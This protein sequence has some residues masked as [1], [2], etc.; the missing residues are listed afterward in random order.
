MYFL[1]I[2][3]VHSQNHYNFWNRIAVSHT[4]TENIKAEFEIQNRWQNDLYSNEK[5]WFEDKLMNSFRLWMYYRIHDHLTLLISPISYFENNPII[6]NIGDENKSLTYENRYSVLIERNVK[7]L[8]KTSFIN[9]VGIEYRDFKNSA[10]DYFRAREKLTFKYDLS[11]KYAVLAYDELFINCINKDGI[12]IFD[13]NRTGLSVN[14]TGIKNLKLELGYMYNYRSQRN[15]D[16]HLSE[17][18]LTVNTYY[19]IPKKNKWT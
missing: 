9:K 2:L 3:S 18:N 16:V 17:N 13:Q 1:S 6:R 4:L 7:I 15:T 10:P 8:P 11:S 12:T 5:I 14:Y 19:S